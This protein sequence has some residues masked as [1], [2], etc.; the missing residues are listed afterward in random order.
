MDVSSSD[1]RR[2]QTQARQSLNHDEVKGDSSCQ[3]TRIQLANQVQQEILQQAGGSIKNLSVEVDLETIRISGRCEKFYTKQLAQSI[4][5]LVA[6]EES[7]RNSIE[8]AEN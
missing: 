8:V 6:G 1:D 7:V 3:Q 4:A 5:M 2:E